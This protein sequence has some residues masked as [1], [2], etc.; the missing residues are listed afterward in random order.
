MLRAGDSMV[1]TGVAAGAD[2]F[3]QGFVTGPCAGQQGERESNRCAGVGR[4]PRGNFVGD[5]RQHGRGPCGAATTARGNEVALPPF[6]GTV[7]TV[8]DV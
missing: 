8:V 7:A 5:R 4:Q 6:A 2:V 3:A 1:S